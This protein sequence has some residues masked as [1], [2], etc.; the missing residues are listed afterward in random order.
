M[1][2][3]QIMCAKSEKKDMPT[4]S[5]G[6]PDPLK[7]RPSI[8]SDTGMVKTSPVNSTRVFLLSIPLVPSKTWC[9]H[10]LRSFILKRIISKIY[11]VYEIH[12]ASSNLHDSLA[13][14][15][16]KHLAALHFS[17]TQSQSHD[18]GIFWEL[19][20]GKNQQSESSYCIKALNFNTVYK[21]LGNS[22]G[23]QSA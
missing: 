6:L 9:V 4:L 7:I 2:F 16:L 12:Q 22:N 21:D 17:I 10:K 18:L 13:S 23:F 14:R 5:M 1:H 20:T 15:D 11:A 3:V 8:S 19:E